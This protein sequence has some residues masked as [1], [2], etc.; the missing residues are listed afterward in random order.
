MSKKNMV[1]THSI[2]A[3]KKTYEIRFST[4]AM[5]RLEQE[6]GTSVLGIAEAFSKGTGMFK[7][8][9]HM[10]WAGL[11]GARV[12]RGEEAEAFTLESA[13]NVIDE[14]GGIKEVLGCIMEPF[15]EAFPKAET[16][17][18]VEAVEKA[19]K[20]LGG[21][22]SENPTKLKKVLKNDG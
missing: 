7:E 17:E 6:L 4:Y 1:D 12:H 19:M 20:D 16:P 9:V 14:M 3:G 13:A 10:L 11:E 2:K 18:E 5:M 22:A 8:A 21:A 15:T